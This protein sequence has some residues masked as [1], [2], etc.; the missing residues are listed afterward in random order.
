MSNDLRDMHAALTAAGVSGFRLVEIQTAPDLDTAYA[1]H[2]QWLDED[3]EWNGDPRKT[4]EEVAAILAA[5]VSPEPARAARAAALES[6]F[7]SVGAMERL[8]N[9][10][11]AQIDAF[12]DANVTDLPSARAVL[13]VLA[14]AVAYLARGREDD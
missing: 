13:K 14:K 3:G 2:L 1:E 9:A 7:K 6:E 5:Y 12:I 11:P 8:R 10:T 4:R